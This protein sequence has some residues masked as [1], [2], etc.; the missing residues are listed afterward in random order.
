MDAWVMLV[1]AQAGASFEV[2]GRLTE[3]VFGL[4]NVTVVRGYFR[5]PFVPTR[6][7]AFR[8]EQSSQKNT[9]AVVNS[10]RLSLGCRRKFRV[11]VDQ[12]A[13]VTAWRVG[14]TTHCLQHGR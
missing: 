9:R 3:L 6:A 2:G 10:G 8:R 12:P 7:S 14:K 4:K 13:D 11:V 5:R 1:W